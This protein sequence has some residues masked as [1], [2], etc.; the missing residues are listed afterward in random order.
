MTT[1]DT[2]SISR[3]GERIKIPEFW[4]VL[5]VKIPYEL[6]ERTV[7]DSLKKLFPAI[8]LAHLNYAVHAHSYPN[9]SLYA[10]S[11]PN[12]HPTP[13]YGDTA[14]INMP[15]AWTLETGKPFIKVGIL[16]S[17]I[18]WYHE[19]FGNGTF[20]GSKIEGG[21]NY[22]KQEPLNPVDPLPDDFGHGT[23]CAG[24]AGALS[25]NQKGIA[26]IAGGDASLNN[27]GA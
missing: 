4:S 18:D 12:L 6:P 11:Q 27:P 25:N 13:T 22:E 2:V 19:D 1:K 20:E 16:D 10:A 23:S 17:G 7:C 5:L 21:Y 26:G 15:L 24:I 8:Q 3:M 9:D 14:G